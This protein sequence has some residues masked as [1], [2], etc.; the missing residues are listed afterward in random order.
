[1]VIEQGREIH[2][3]SLKPLKW[4]AEEKD[5]RSR[6]NCHTKRQTSAM[7]ETYTYIQVLF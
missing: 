6:Q 2:K 5:I 1:M 7:Y 3:L 4:G